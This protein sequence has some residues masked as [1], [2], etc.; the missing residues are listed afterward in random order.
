[1]QEKPWYKQGVK[2]VHRTWE[3][4]MKYTKFFCNQAQNTSVS[5][6]NIFQNLR[7]LSVLTIIPI[8]IQVLTKAPKVNGSGIG[9]R[10]P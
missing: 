9:F 3:D 4:E 1:L 7:T 8:A 10:T 6:Y 2:E 5:Q